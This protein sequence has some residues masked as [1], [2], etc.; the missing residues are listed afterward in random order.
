MF[1]FSIVPVITMATSFDVQCVE[2]LNDNNIHAWRMKMEFF[3]HEKNLWK[4]ILRKLLPPEIKS[5]K[6]DPKGNLHEP[7]MFMKKDKLAHEAIFL[8]VVDFKLH[9]VSCAKNAKDM[10]NNLYATF[11]K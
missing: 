4:I 9:H 11:E 5:R 2:K 3:M 7:C 8:N 10:Q 1:I 6:F